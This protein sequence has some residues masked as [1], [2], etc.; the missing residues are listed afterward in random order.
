MHVAHPAPL[1]WCRWAF[2]NQG[3]SALAG[4]TA[5]APPTTKVAK[6][7]VVAPD[8]ATDLAE[9]RLDLIGP[10]QTRVSRKVMLKRCR[11]RALA[12]RSSIDRLSIQNCL[13]TTGRGAA[14]ADGPLQDYLTER[15][16]NLT[17]G[18]ESG[19]R[20]GLYQ[21]DFRRSRGVVR[22]SN[23]LH[24][25]PSYCEILFASSWGLASEVP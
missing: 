5:T 4:R 8:N 24:R 7:S 15:S 9:R 16:E 20:V 10:P 17:D 22:R 1:W 2:L 11:S 23:S 21:I 25:R 12:S 18:S 3:N 14:F 13:C 19:A 6:A